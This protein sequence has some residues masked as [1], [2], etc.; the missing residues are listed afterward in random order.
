MK[1]RIYKI[2]RNSGCIS[3]GVVFPDGT[4]LLHW[5]TDYASTSIYKSFEDFKTLQIDNVKD[6]I[7]HIDITDVGAI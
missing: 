3:I 5:I 2:E 1:L 7:K 4:V 6:K